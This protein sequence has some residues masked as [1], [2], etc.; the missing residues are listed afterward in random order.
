[1]QNTYPKT[2]QEELALEIARGLGEEP[3][4]PIYRSFVLRHPEEV[5]RRAYQEAMDFP[6]EKIRKTRGA[7]FNYLLKK[8]ARPDQSNSQNPGN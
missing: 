4:L 8:Y 7:I 3:L 2:K 6:V 5:V 1:M